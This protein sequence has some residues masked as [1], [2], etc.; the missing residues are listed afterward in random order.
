MRRAMPADSA[1]AHGCYTGFMPTPPD[2]ASLAERYLDLW[3]EQVAAL[4]NDPALAAAMAGLLRVFDAAAR[5]ADRGRQG[6]GGELGT[7]DAAAAPGGTA[8]AAAASRGSQP[9]HA[10]LARRLAECEA[11][12]AALEAAARPPRRGTPAK[13]RRR[14]T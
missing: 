11:R 7:A 14:R 9:D 5:L 3:Q 6:A 8:A 13:P 12:L 1:A 2:L 10:E 4:A